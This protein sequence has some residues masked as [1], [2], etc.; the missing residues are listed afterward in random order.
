M[1]L[2]PE[3]KIDEKRESDYGPKR[4][5]VVLPVTGVAHPRLSYY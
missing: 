3:R 1:L 4:Y 2:W 5:L